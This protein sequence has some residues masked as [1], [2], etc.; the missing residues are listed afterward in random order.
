MQC[1][2]VPGHEQGQAGVFA[3]P[4]SSGRGPADA[5]AG[6][7]RRTP[8]SASLRSAAH[9]GVAVVKDEL[10]WTGVAAPTVW[11]GGALVMSHVERDF[12]REL[13]W[14]AWP[15]GL[16]LG[17]HGAG[18]V[19]VF[20]VFA[21][22]YTTF[23]VHAARVATWSRLARFGSR[24]ALAGAVLTPLL[25]FQTD[26]PGRDA[27][28][29][30]VL[31]A[32]GYFALVASVLIALV[33]LSPGLLRREPRAWRSAPA[34]LAL[35]PLALLAPNATVRSSYLVFAV[36]FTLLAALA[37]ALRHSCRP[38]ALPEQRTGGAASVTGRHL[39]RR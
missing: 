17:P 36:P 38:A 21:G 3:Q 30:G 7:L 2:A 31:H 4:P 5:S 27:T 39:S 1:G 14:D 37:L 28:W 16:A 24:A 10:A 19:L 9:R 12:M 35:V 8:G 23:A 6:C 15:S 13:G 11:L 22:L 33:T 32:V 34:A 26:P 25:A 18:Q 29:H 20:L